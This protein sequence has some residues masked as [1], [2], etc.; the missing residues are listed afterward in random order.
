MALNLGYIY[1][2]IRVKDL[3]VLPPTEIRNNEHAYG[4]FIERGTWRLKDN[5]REGFKD[6]KREKQT[7][8]HI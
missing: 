1:G 6:R 2:I 8:N 5:T 7:E 3:K 4:I